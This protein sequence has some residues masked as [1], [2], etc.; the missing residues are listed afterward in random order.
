MCATAFRACATSC[1]RYRR[2]GDRQGRGRCQSDHLDRFSSDQHSALEVTDVANRIV[3]PRLQTLPGAADVRVFGERK[4]AMRIWLDRDRLAAFNLTPQDV[5][6][7]LRRQNVEVPAGRIESESREFSVVART[8][9]TE[10]AQF[11]E[12]IVKQAADARAATRCASP[13]SAGSRSAPLRSAAACASRAGRQ[14]PWGSSS[15]RRRTRSNSRARC[16]PSCR[17]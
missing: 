13:T 12:I 3:K 9:L 1:R 14:S 2:A 8:D 15:R 17:R 6:D 11:A 10:P 7:A 5:E 4:F 16:A